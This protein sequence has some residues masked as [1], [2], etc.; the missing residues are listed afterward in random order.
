[1]RSKTL[2]SS[3]TLLVALTALLAASFAS[4]A[5]AQDDRATVRKILDKVG[6]KDDKVEDVADF[7]REGRVI[8]LNLTRRGLSTEPFSE[9][10]A[11]ILHLTALKGLL[12]K[13]NSIKSIPHEIGNLTGLIEIDLANNTD[14]GTL[15]PSM[16]NLTNL[17]KLDVRFCGLSTLPFSFGNLKSLEM[18][19]LWGNYFTDLPSCV[20]EMT[21][22]KDLHLNNN[23]ITTLPPDI[24]KMPNLTYIDVQ[25][26]NICNVAPTVDAWLTHL[27]KGWKDHQWCENVKH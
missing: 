11:E 10:P 21:A 9:F 7:S 19:Q 14:I 15:P 23:K 2:V 8:K 12:L 20:T 17:K 26:N 5:C 6:R 4:P 22:L 24:V 16:G 25:R 13:G 3:L 1:M 18:L 27:S